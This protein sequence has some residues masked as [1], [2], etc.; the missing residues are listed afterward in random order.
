MGAVP[1]AYGVITFPCFSGF[2]YNHIL[3]EGIILNQERNP[4]Q[5]ISFNSCFKLGLQKSLC[6]L[7]NLTEILSG[8]LTSTAQLVGCCLA[9]Q[10][11]TGSVSSQ[12]TSLGGGF[13][14]GQGA[15]EKQLLQKQLIQRQLMD[16]SFPLFLPPFPFLYK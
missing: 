9:K 7:N 8:A 16:A 14:P 6:H 13:C 4:P 2:R 11:V 12:D 3:V 15:Y 1:K 10:K 5:I